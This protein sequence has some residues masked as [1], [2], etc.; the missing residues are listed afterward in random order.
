[1]LKYQI[2]ISKNDAKGKKIINISGKKELIYSNIIF[3]NVNKLV[4][5]IPLLNYSSIF[6]ALRSRVMLQLTEQTVNSILF[7]IYI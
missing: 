4:Y 3:I 2:N 5:K 6:I 7:F 1:M